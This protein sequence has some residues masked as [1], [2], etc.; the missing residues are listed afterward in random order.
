MI[1]VVDVHRLFNCCGYND[2][3]LLSHEAQWVQQFQLS[4]LCVAV[5]RAMPDEVILCVVDIDAVRVVDCGVILYDSG[6]LTT[7][8]LN[9]LASPVADRSESLDVE[10]LVLK[11]LGLQQTLLDKRIFVQQGADAIVDAQAR[12]FGASSDTSL[13]NKLAC[14][15]AFSVDVLLTDHRLVSVH[16]PGHYLLVGAHVRSKAVNLWSNKALFGEFHSVSSCDPFELSLRVLAWV[17][18]DS[19]F[20]TSERHVGNCKLES[21]ERSEGHALLDVDV[22]SI[23][24]A[25]LAWEVVMLV[26]RT[27]TNDVLDFSVVSA[28]GD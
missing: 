2:V 23:P 6:D 11:S 7:V 25:A 14:S 13:I 9:E 1:G 8:P 5:K 27:V 24:G 15:A 17:N 16:D 22:I 28:D 26:L 21:H 4:S 12:A 3:A 18:L 10:C 20:G 19:S